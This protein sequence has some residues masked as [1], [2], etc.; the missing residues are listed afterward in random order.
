MYTSKESARR[1]VVGLGT[2]AASLVV[3]YFALTA[4][5]GRLP[6][7]PV[8]TVKAAFED[9]GQLQPGSDVRQNGVIVGQVSSIVSVNGKPVVTME[10]NRG[11][12]MYRNGYAGVWDR[13]SLAQKFVELR[14]GDPSS[15]SLGEATLPVQQTESTHDLVQVLDVFDARTRAA[16]GNALRELG[17]G[18]AGYGPGLHGFVASAP[19]V[20][21]DVGTIST[22]LASDRT[23]LPGLLETGNRLS[24]RFT[25]REHQIN[26]LL[27]QTDETLRALGIDGSRPLGETVSRLPGAL[28]AARTALGDAEQPLADLAAATGTLRPGG[29]SLGDAT[30]DVRGV[31]R[32]APAPL[33]RVP[34]VADDAN[35]AVDD[36][37]DTFSH[38]QAFSPK[39]ADGLSSASPPLKVLAP[40]ARDI[41]TFG[42][43]FGNLITGHDGWEH[44]LR[45]WPTVSPTTTVL[46]NTIKDSRNPYPAPGQATLERDANGGLIPGDPGR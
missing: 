18:L 9:V 5:E 15:G 17:G 31:F 14:S 16:L 10:V 36:L 22:T 20:L 19:S 45:I 6:G 8:T 37:R 30:P 40:Y 39:L 2:L 29:R 25:D 11:V 34:D 3:G 46:G 43:D 42:T 26:E 38:A 24:G 21:G 23:D 28:R 27:R 35:P 32:E 1:F 13:S 41:G 44:H 7:M 4:N 12:P 33:S